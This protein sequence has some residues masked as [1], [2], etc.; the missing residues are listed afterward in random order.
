MTSSTIVF[1][2]RANA[3]SALRRGVRVIPFLPSVGDE[4][5]DAVGRLH[6]FCFAPNIEL[7]FMLPGRRVIE[8]GLEIHEWRHE[9]EG[10]LHGRRRGEKDVEVFRAA[11]QPRPDFRTGPLQ[12]RPQSSS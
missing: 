10:D 2:H 12:L 7:D 4:V 9:G 1:E 5:A 6:G 3:P 11:S 8:G